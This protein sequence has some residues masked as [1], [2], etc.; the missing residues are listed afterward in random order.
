[1]FIPAV[2]ILSLILSVDY[3]FTFP[4]LPIKLTI[5]LH[6]SPYKKYSRITISLTSEHFV[7]IR[8]ATRDPLHEPASVS[9]SSKYSG[10]AG[11]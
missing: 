6:T 7:G 11:E 4:H 9:K 2:K 5:S 3:C 1:M 10:P 8:T